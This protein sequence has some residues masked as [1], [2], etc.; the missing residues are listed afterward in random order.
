MHTSFH[1]IHTHAG[2]GMQAHHGGQSPGAID[3]AYVLCYY[4]N[5]TLIS[6]V[7]IHYSLATIYLL[8]SESMILTMCHENKLLLNKLILLQSRSSSIKI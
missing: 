8:Y 4:N 2:P 3:V 5:E 7:T 1:A 6:L